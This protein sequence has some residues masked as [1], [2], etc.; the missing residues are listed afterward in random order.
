MN[1]HQGFTLIELMIVVAIVGILAAIAYPSYQD[2]I[3]KSARAVAKQ[4][5]FEVVSRQE[6]N[7]LNSKAYA[8]DLTNL[9]YSGTTYYVNKQGDLITTSANS[10]Y[11]IR[12]ATG[13]STSAFTV[14]AVPQNAQTGDTK[15]GTLS[16]SSTGVKGETGTGTSATCW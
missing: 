16:L 1:K 2:S 11:L 6:N 5:L 15:C 8:T 3:R 9:G 13:M 12:L 14:E 7:Y 4:A 10:I